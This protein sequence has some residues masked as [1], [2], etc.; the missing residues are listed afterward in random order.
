MITSQTGGL[1]TTPAGHG[2]FDATGTITAGSFAGSTVTA[3]VVTDQDAVELG[4]ACT[5]KGLKK[6]TSAGQK[7][8][9]DDGLIGSGSTTYTAAP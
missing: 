3:H 1:S 8:S 2:Q 6:E 5:G 4:A 7:A 9:K